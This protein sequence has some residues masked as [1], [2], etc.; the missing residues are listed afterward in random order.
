APQTVLARYVVDTSSMTIDPLTE[1]ELLRIDQPFENH[2]GGKLLFGP[3]GMLYL[4]TGDGGGSGDP[5]NTAQN[6]GSLLGKMLRLDVSS[7]PYS[8]PA[9]NPFAGSAGARPEIWS[10]GLRNPWKV[11]FDRAT[12]D[13]WIA[14]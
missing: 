10:Y 14:D 6:L 1:Q 7:L 2:N 11:S 12:G 9:G 13:L 5:S 3:D 8:I 4:S